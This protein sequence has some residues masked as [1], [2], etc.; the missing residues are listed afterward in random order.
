MMSKV[1]TVRIDLLVINFGLR[2]WSIIDFSEC[3]TALFIELDDRQLAFS[4]L[5]A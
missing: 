3:S 2:E 1:T 5:L 4:V